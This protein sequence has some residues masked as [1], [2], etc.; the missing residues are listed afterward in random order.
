MRKI[1]NQIKIPFLSYQIDI[2]FVLLYFIICFFIFGYGSYFCF[3]KNLRLFFLEKKFSIF[4]QVF[5][6]N[7]IL[8]SIFKRILD[9]PNFQ[10]LHPELFELFIYIIFLIDTKDKIFTLKLKKRRKQNSSAS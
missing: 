8:N 3:S 5:F 9:K 7:I 6:F 1:L 4:S 10:I 2:N